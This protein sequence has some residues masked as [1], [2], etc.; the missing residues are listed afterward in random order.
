MVI[1]KFETNSL[2]SKL[3]LFFLSFLFLYRRL[4]IIDIPN[5]YLSNYKII[6]YRIKNR[7]PNKVKIEK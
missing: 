3:D 6:I 5:N 1:Y 4:H 7:V 2:L